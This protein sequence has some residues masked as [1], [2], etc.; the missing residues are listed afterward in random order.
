VTVLDRNRPPIP[1]ELSHRADPECLPVVDQ[2]YSRQK[3]GTPQFVPPGRCIVLKAMDRGEVKAVWVTGWPETRYVKHEW[4]GA[5]VNNVFAKVGGPWLA[6]EMIRAAVAVSRWIAAG[7]DNWGIPPALGLV[8][9]VDASKVR[10][11]NP[12]YCYLCAGF[13]RVG[14]TKGGLISYQMLPPLMPEPMPPRER[15]ILMF[16]GTSR[17]PTPPPPPLP[18]SSPPTTEER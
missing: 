18:P 15:Q 6:S 17:A 5:W 11:R 9:F 7:L 12:G 13:T 16:A 14:M 8:S 1:W 10:S 3:P 4:A 2:H